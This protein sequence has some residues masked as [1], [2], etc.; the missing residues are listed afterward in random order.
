M[1]EPVIL[2]EDEYLIAVNKPAGMLSEE[3]A[4]RASLP[5]VL[6]GLTGSDIFTVHRLDRT[7]HGLT[8]Y[9]K[10][11]KAAA[12]LSA[13]IQRGDFKKTYLA[14]AEG[15]TG[16]RGE[17]SDLLYYDR[18]RNKSFV[19]KRERKGV[20]RASL[21]F[22]RLDTGEYKGEAVSLV[23]VALRT[24]RTH[25]IRVQFASA[26]HPLV[27]DRQ[28]GSRIACENIALC[29]AGLSFIHPETGERLTFTCE[30]EGVAFGVFTQK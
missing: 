20:K 16:D 13:Q 23:R 27:G 7:T 15:V 19:V 8:V 18:S 28:Y 9:A 17:L 4:G 11:A 6:R 1:R 5:A 22:E 26:K 25:Q 24:G 21:S 3:H 30:P 10:T 14:V 29:S 2:Y 12:D